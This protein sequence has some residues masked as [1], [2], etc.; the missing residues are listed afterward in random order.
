MKFRLLHCSWAH[1]P[2][3]EPEYRTNAICIEKS[4]WGPI[5]QRRLESCSCHSDSYRQI[6]KEP[7]HP[8]YWGLLKDTDHLFYVPKWTSFE[9]LV[10]QGVSEPLRGPMGDALVMGARER[11]CSHLQTLRLAEAGT[12]TTSEGRSTSAAPGRAAHAAASTPGTF[13]TQGRG[14][15]GIISRRAWLFAKGVRFVVLPQYDFPL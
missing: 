12:A 10:Q 8:V 5:F 2:E 4:T 1:H 11:H 15:M 9:N 3:M 6:F 13:S 14:A 7:K